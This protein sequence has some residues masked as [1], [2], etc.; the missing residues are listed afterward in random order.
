[1]TKRFTPEQL[2]E[3]ARK[4]LE[5]ANENE[6][7]LYEKIGRLCEQDLFSLNLSEPKFLEF[8]KKSKA[9]LYQ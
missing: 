5:E 6:K 1:M 3:K 7:T 4:L 8:L 2:R 9:I